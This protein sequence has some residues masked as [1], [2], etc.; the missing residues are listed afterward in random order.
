LYDY[1]DDFVNYNYHNI[2]EKNNGNRKHHKKDWIRREAR[3]T[4]RTCG[5]E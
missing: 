1:Y 5:Q 2:R 3:E 4:D